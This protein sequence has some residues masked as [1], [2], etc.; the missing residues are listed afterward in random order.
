MEEASAAAQTSEFR[1]VIYTRWLPYLIAASLM[2]VSIGL[3]VQVGTLKKQLATA[4]NDANHLRRSNALLGLKL[5][6]LDAKDPA[7]ASSRIVVAWDPY[8]HHGVISVEALPP[9]PAG[10]D[11]QLWVLDPNALAPISAGVITESRPIHIDAITTDNPGFAVSLE[12][13]GGS[14]SLG[15][16]ILFAI[17][18]GP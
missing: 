13:T 18:P 5:A 10:H 7:Y 6:W 8:E 17:A 15:G 11:Y 1:S 3:G 4:T 9:A 12:P 16:S 14:A 2:A